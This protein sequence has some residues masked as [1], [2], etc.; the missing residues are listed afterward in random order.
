M[1]VSPRQA[2]SDYATLGEDE[3]LERS[4]SHPVRYL[5]F[6]YMFVSFVCCFVFRLTGDVIQ[7]TL[8]MKQQP[9]VEAALATMVKCYTTLSF[10]TKLLHNTVICHEIVTQHCHLLRNC[11]TLLRFATKLLQSVGCRPT[12]RRLCAPKRVLV[13]RNVR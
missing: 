6:V 3:Y 4:G 9:G 10:A 7:N 5:L 12:M 2:G 1:P 11:C 13:L 8:A